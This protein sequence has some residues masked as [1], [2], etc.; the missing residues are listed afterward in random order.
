MMT[1]K[2][3]LREKVFLIND[4]KHQI[5]GNKLPTKKQV[6]KV[7]FFNMRRLNLS[8]R[9][10]AMFVAKEVIVFW[11]KAGIPVQDK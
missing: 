10:R 2:Y 1:G 5:V 4:I 7:F 8:A 11:E 3:D 9:E 6:S